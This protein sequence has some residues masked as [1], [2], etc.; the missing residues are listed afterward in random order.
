MTEQNTEDPEAVNEAIEDTPTEEPPIKSKKTLR[1]SAEGASRGPAKI[2]QS[3]SRKGC[4]K[5]AKRKQ[6]DPRSFN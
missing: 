3:K 1:A 2:L 6:K 4:N 5:E